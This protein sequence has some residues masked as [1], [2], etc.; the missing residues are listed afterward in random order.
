M[1]HQAS[2]AMHDPCSIL[3]ETLKSESALYTYRAVSSMIQA[4][5]R[6]V[7]LPCTLKR[8]TSR[9]AHLNIPAIAFC[10]FTPEKITPAWKCP[11]LFRTREFAQRNRTACIVWFGLREFR[12]ISQ[13]IYYTT[14]RDARVTVF[15]SHEPQ[16]YNADDNSV[17]TRT[18]QIRI[19]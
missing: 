17:Y 7:T 8:I 5:I 19:V 16:A 6:Y 18:V 2:L 14:A 1:H 3:S 12:T 13:D 11:R 10:S 9:L 15:A 4:Y